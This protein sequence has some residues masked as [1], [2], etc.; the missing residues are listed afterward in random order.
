VLRPA[1]IVGTP[2]IAADRG[3]ARKGGGLIRG[4]ILGRG[5]LGDGKD[6]GVGGGRL[7]ARPPATH[8]VE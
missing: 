8:G 7:A 3:F 5:R 4:Q 6:L 2:V 1:E